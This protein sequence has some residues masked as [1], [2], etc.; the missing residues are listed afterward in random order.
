MILPK[1]KYGSGI[2]TTEQVK[3]GGLNH[4]KSASEGDI[5]DMCNMSSKDYPLISTRTKRA[6]LSS[7]EDVKAVGDRWIIKGTDFIYDGEV[8]N[9]FI[10][11]SDTPKTVV[12][13]GAYVLIFPD[14]YYYN[15]EED[16]PFVEGVYEME[17]TYA[18]GSYGNMGHGVKVN[19]NLE[20]IEYD[21]IPV[22]KSGRDGKWYNQV[23]SRATNTT[24]DN[25]ITLYGSLGE[26]GDK[27]RTAKGFG[28]LQ[29][30][31]EGTLWRS[32]TDE[33]DCVDVGGT[34]HRA[35]CGGLREN[36]VVLIKKGELEQTAVVTEL[37][38]ADGRVLF[39]YQTVSLWEGT[40]EVKRNIPDFEFMCVCE[41]R[42]WG[43]YD[44]TIYASKLGD[45]K[46][47]YVYQALSTDSWAIDYMT[48]TFTGA[49]VYNG[50][51][52]FW[53]EDSVIT[54]Y[55]NTPFTYQAS[56]TNLN[57][58]LNGAGSSMT[59][60]GGYLYYLSPRGLCVYG[61]RYPTDIH[62]PINEKITSGYGF[63]DGKKYYIDTVGKM[64]VYDPS[65]H[66]WHIEESTGVC[67][68]NTKDGVLNVV[69]NDGDLYGFTGEGD[70]V[71]DSF[72][73]FGDFYLNTGDKKAV[74]KLNI[75]LEADEGAEIEIKVKYD[76]EEWQ[77]V[78]VL[79]ATTKRSFYLPF[80]PR[81]CD[82][83]RL[84]FE[85]KGGYTIYSMSRENYIGSAN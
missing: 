48:K 22:W 7:G 46:N 4:I 20:G 15:A 13:M 76:S 34:K 28:T 52:T 3:F 80:V 45:P 12:E 26:V 58:V 35:L 5:Y 83:Y 38:D 77:T 57:G 1:L 49:I 54:I 2:R 18:G 66:L 24:I 68:Y 78:K 69:T 63:T 71:I 11:L 19:Q 23:I 8:K 82:H 75:R 39:P 44:G 33:Y 31:L 17:I 67:N 36:D 41:N 79:T 60:V 47:F 43:V 32:N 64:Y 21:Y 10:P 81:R 50:K 29:V 37:G 61:G 6:L 70:E 72:V 59:V 55:G 51:P 56:E 30:S 40:V 73:E 62:V 65:V 84:R 25:S 14:K 16:K 85:G 42:L 9:E 53:T 74:S 27:I